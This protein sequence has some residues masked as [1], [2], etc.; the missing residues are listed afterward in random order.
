MSLNIWR[1]W[2]SFSPQA[3]VRRPALGLADL[4][5]G[6]GTLALLYVITR[7]GAESFEERLYKVEEQEG[8]QQP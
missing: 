1:N 6:L 4:A 8:E 3:D 7:V 5:V 2:R